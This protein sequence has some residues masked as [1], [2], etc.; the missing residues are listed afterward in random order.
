MPKCRNLP[1]IQ[2]KLHV[3]MQSFVLIWDL[4]D[5][6]QSRLPDDFD[7]TKNRQRFLELWS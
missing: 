3:T 5:N 6:S 1:S 7:T 2:K 4:G